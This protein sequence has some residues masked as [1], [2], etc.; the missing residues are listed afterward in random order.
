MRIL[1]LLYWNLEILCKPIQIKNI[2]LSN[3]MPKRFSFCQILYCYTFTWLDWIRPNRP[4]RIEQRKPNHPLITNNNNKIIMR[5]L[6][7]PP[8]PIKQGEKIKGKKK[9]KK[10]NWNTHL[11]SFGL[12][13]VTHTKSCL[14]S[15]IYA[16]RPYKYPAIYG[17]TRWDNLV[18]LTRAHSTWPHHTRAPTWTQVLLVGNRITS[19]IWYRNKKYSTTWRHRNGEY[20]CPR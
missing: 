10:K 5:Q 18:V 4:I 16:Q 9:V 11:K 17:Q 2:L 7:H 3:Q 14:G 6:F 15:I 19:P 8:T 12:L 1:W 13:F 20:G